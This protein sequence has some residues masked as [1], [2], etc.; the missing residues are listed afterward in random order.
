M[1]VPGIE[2]AAGVCAEA[3]CAETEQD[4]AIKLRNRNS[5]KAF[6]P[7][8]WFSVPLGDSHYYRKYQY[9]YL[10]ANFNNTF[11]AKHLSLRWHPEVV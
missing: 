11:H 4:K 5:R 8:T 1:D 9:I 10:N 6:K 2:E 7:N 3:V